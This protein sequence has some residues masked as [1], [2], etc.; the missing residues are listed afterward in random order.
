M[1]YE[2]ETINREA[3]T[4]KVATIIMESPGYKKI[5][6]SSIKKERLEFLNRANV[7]AN[8]MNFSKS[9]IY[10]KLCSKMLKPCLGKL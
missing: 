2:E 8:Y 4:Y 5:N 1:E 7:Y 9:N 6:N 10:T 3:S